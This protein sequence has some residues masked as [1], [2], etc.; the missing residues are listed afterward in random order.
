MNKLTAS[1][2][3]PLVLTE[4]K[5]AAPSAW[6]AASSKEMTSWNQSVAQNMDKMSADDGYRQELAK[7]LS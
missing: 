4:T 7:K 2:P 1:L 3:S 6:T 5:A